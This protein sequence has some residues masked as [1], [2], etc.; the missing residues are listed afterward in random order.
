[1]LFASQ[2]VTMVVQVSLQQKK[3]N[4]EFAQVKDPHDM[5]SAVYRG[6][7]ATNQTKQNKYRYRYRERSFEIGQLIR[8]DT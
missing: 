5:I 7:K 3:L 8:N 6:R 2:E 1:M 4:F